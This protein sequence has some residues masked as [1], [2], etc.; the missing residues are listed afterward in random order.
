MGDET[1]YVMFYNSEGK[2]TYDYRP[3]ITFG[4]VCIMEK[5]GKV[6]NSYSARSFR[7]GFEWLTDEVVDE[8]AK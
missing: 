8:I 4:A 1:A 2:L 7:K 5:E 3:M 6:E